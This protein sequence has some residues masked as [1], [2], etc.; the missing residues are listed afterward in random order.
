MQA[1]S[2]EQEALEASSAKAQRLKA[3]KRIPIN[4]AVNGAVFCFILQPLV[5]L[6]YIDI[7]YVTPH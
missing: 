5:Y 2:I 7:Y 6:D 3:V 1:T 4:R